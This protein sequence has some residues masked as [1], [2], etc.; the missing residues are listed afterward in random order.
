MTESA[1]APLRA[2]YTRELT[3]IVGAPLLVAIIGWA[4]VWA[5]LALVALATTAALWEFLTFGQAKGYPVQKT[6]SI[7]LLMVLLW[8][9]VDPRVSV[10]LGVFSILLAIPAAYV[11]ARTP[12]EEALPASAVSALGTLYVGM[13]GG[14]LIRLRTDFPLVGP[15]LIFFLLIVVWAA[16]TGAYYVGRK[17]GRHPLSPRVSPKKTVEGALGGIAAALLAAA[18]VHATFLPELPLLPALGA[19]ILLAL[20]G[21]IGDLAESMWK[22]S[23]AVKDSGGL[24]PGHG[25]FLDRIDSI[26]FTAPILYGY[27]FVLHEAWG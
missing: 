17:L 1:S 16:D 13:L 12:L 11:F 24:I 20:A 7:L 21:M 10:E 9:F 3:A 14:A 25:G 6:L 22:R 2:R 4:P 27:W 26:L 19:S 18:V 8:T 23:A 15:R 5:Y